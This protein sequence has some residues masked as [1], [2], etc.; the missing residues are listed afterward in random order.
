MGSFLAE[1]MRDAKHVLS[2][3]AEEF[4]RVIG[5]KWSGADEAADALNAV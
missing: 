1:A 4:R 5:R 2:K 3:V